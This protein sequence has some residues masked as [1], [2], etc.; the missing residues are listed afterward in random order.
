MG[1]VTSLSKAQLL[2]LLVGIPKY[3]ANTVFFVGGQSI[4]P[5]QVVTGI[6]SL[7]D[8]GAASSAAMA[9][10]K[11]AMQ[12]EEKALAQVGQM[13][14]EVRDSVALMY[15]GVPTTLNAFAIQPR[16]PAKPLSAEA[17]AAATAKLRATR[18][19]RGT[20][21]KKQK[22]Q[23]TGNVTGVSIVPITTPASPA[24]TEAPPAATSPATPATGSGQAAATHS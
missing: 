14:R 8:A 6:H 21:S 12:S 15:S 17:R 18:K 19:A 1:K 16:K 4:T 23:I 22:A 20:T 11:E 13:V 5:A 10:W 2:G 24:P 7:L 9:S 3:C